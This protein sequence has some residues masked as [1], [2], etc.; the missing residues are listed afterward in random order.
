MTSYCAAFTVRLR[1]IS[2]SAS[3]SRFRCSSRRRRA[4]DGLRPGGQ[5]AVGIAAALLQ[6]AEVEHC[7]GEGRVQFQR[8][9]VRGFGVG[10]A[11]GQ[12]EQRAPVEAGHLLQRRGAALDPVGIERDGAVE[13]TAGL[14]RLR[15]LHRLRQRERVRLAG[16]GSG[17]D[18]GSVG[19]SDGGHG[20]PHAW[21]PSILGRP[22]RARA[23]N[24][25][26]NTAHFARCTRPDPG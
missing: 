16:G 14:Q 18:S 19:G 15:T 8:P 26:D 24:R 6:V 25:P 7:R 2:F 10:L 13:V 1:T 11:V 20:A 17:G 3:G 23:H 9:A 4:L 5:R 12:R 21:I 22:P